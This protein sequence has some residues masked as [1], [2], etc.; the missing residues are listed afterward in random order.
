M[1][2]IWLVVSTMLLMACDKGD[3]SLSPSLAYLNYESVSCE[4]TINKIITEGS[5]SVKYTA[6]IVAGDDWCSFDIKSK[7]LVR[8]AKAS[9]AAF[10]YFSRNTSDEPRSA[11]IEVEFSDGST[12]SLEMVQGQYSASAKYDHKW[13]ELPVHQAKP[14]YIYKTYFVDV[15]SGT[16][17]YK[18]M[19]NYTI[20]YDTDKT[21]SH[22]VAYP[23]HECYIKGGKRT[24]A[25]SY[26][27]NDQQPVIP[28]SEQQYILKSYNTGHARGHILPSATRLNSYNSE[29]NEQTFYATNM[30]PQHYEFNGGVWASLEGKVRENMGKNDGSRDTLYVVTGTHFA[31]NK[32]VS[33][34]MGTRI[35]VPSHAYKVLLRARNPLP[36]GKTIADLSADELI[37][38]G[39]WFEN[40]DVGENTTI[41][42]AACTVNE[43][44]ER[45]GFTFFGNLSQEAA[46]VKGRYSLSDWSGF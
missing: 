4:E 11:Q 36:A 12:F 16:S 31:D 21:I 1:S 14:Q 19:R 45:T 32:T 23:V 26:D 13:A 22:W 37:A 46:S 27:P 8:E 43:I 25:W 2:L 15:Y 41:R 44:E 29:V 40:S 17:T 34:R 24:N 3:D 7:V 6:T 5:S 28:T 38:I 35:A 20:C 42:E 33:D 9:N 10:L 18:T 39:F 30:M